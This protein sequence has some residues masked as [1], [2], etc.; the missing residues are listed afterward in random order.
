MPLWVQWFVRAEWHLV[1]VEMWTMLDEMKASP[2]H[3]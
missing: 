1:I 2:T 3:Q